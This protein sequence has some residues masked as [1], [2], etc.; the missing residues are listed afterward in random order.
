MLRQTEKNGVDRNQTLG[1]QSLAGRSKSSPD[2]QK[3][4][5]TFRGIGFQE[6]LS[7]STRGLV[8]KRPRYQL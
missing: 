5:R 3:I 7:V 1:G 6:T 2:D 4:L 8:G